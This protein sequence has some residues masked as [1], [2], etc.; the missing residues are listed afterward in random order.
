M[1]NWGQYVNVQNEFISSVY[2]EQRI[3]VMDTEAED[4]GVP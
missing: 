4:P 3:L 2:F 1:D